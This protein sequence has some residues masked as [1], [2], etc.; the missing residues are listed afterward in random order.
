MA[1][2]RITELEERFEK[3]TLY[4]AYTQKGM[5]NIKEQLRDIEAVYLEYA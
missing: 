5:N 1:E 4:V 3:I 2:E